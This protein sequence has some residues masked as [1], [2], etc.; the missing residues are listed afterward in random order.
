M[1]FTLDEYRIGQLY[2]TTLES[3]HNTDGDSSVQVL[4]NEPYHEH[5]VHGSGQYTKKRM[6]FGSKLPRFLDY[7]LPDDYKIVEEES[8]NSFPTCHTGT[9]LL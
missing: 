2:T 9:Q 4:A 6:H 3:R 8:F 1:P 5:A 7:I